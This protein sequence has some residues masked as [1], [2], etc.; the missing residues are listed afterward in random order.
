[1]DV[2][3]LLVMTGALIIAAFAHLRGLQAGIVTVTLAAAISFIPG[4]PRL[5]LDPELI[6]GVVIPPLL[7]SA[8]L[9]FSFFAFVKNLRSI[10]GLGVGLVVF[11]TVVVGFLTSWIAPEIGLAGAF[12]LAAVVSPPDSVTTV[13]HGREIGLPRR[14]ISILTGESLVNDAAALTLFAVAVAAVT[15]DSEF[16]ENPF[17]L[18]GWEALIGLIL[19]VIVGRVVVAVRRRVGNPTIESGLN[20]LVPFLAY[21]A[22]EQLHAS[23]IIAVVAA[24]FT[25]SIS[26]FTVRPS[27]APSTAYRT[28]LQ[29]AALWPVVDLIL[30][31][32]VFAY[33]GLQFRF[34]L[35]DLAESSTPTWSTIGLGLIV[36]LAVILCRFAWVYFSYGRA[37]LALLIYAKRMA[38]SLD[39]TALGR[40]RRRGSAR[41][42]D[43]ASAAGRDDGRGSGRGSGRGGGRGGGRVGRRV[44]GRDGHSGPLGR[45]G[46]RDR[47]H[48]TVLTPAEN[49]LVSWTGMRGIITFAAAGGIP[50]TIA[51]GAP[52]PGRTIIQTVAFIVAVGTLLLQGSTLPLLAKTLRIDTSAEDAEVEEGRADARAAAAAAVAGRE[53]RTSGEYFDLQRAALTQA[54]VSREVS[55]ASAGDVRHELDALQAGVT[56][57]L[58]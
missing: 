10:L 14:T 38:A 12:V 15:G 17:L 3:L 8:T 4:L 28:R 52:F 56:P 58:D 18:F 6:L 55:P 48:I 5:E 53:D 54:V 50:L 57:L 35:E 41:P 40:R 22:A 44:G 11:T 27:T 29:E 43:P 49:L 39:P 26:H 21:F 1:M 16:I 13:S 42:A 36:L 20:L 25:V 33:M 23:G 32:F 45:E 34:V 31:A 37:Q 9:N 46:G 24:G 47:G 2:Q 19:G 7:Y 51:S 30:E